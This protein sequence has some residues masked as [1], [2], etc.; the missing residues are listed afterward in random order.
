MANG[1][2]NL[3]RMDKASEF[4]KKG[5]DDLR[6][7]LT[8]LNALSNPTAEQTQRKLGIE[9]EIARL[10]QFVQKIKTGE[11]PIPATE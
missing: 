4:F 11:I 10:S 6:A 3:G 1:Y 8:E 2:F 5:M 7:E 9:N